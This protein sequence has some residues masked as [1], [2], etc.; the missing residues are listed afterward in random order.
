MSILR[1]L[2]FLMATVPFAAQGFRDGKSGR[3]AA[4]DLLPDR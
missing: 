1:A 4:T 2:K 3:A